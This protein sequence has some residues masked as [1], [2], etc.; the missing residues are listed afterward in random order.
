MKKALG[1]LMLGLGLLP[2]NGCGDDDK[3]GGSSSDPVALCKE[4]A[5]TLCSKFFSCYT[6]DRISAAAAIVGNN[7]ADCVTKFS[8]SDNFNCTTEGTK[9][10]SGDTY[11]AAKANECVSQ[12][13]S[14]S[15][16][17]ITSGN[18]TTPAACEETCE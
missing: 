2:L 1:M 9:C 17:E 7:E 6:K 8:G 5:K 18:V 11:N 3:D 13:K 12:F 15:C 14:L 10:D 4:A 16:N